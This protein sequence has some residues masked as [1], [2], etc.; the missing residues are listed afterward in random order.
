M[1]MNER[2]VN[3]KLG[4]KRNG[5][6]LTY[7]AVR[8]VTNDEEFREASFSSTE[9]AIM[10]MDYNKHRYSWVDNPEG[11]VDAIYYLWQSYE[12]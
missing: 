10:F 1:G 5:E 8:Y 7:I 6:T 3:L 4:D 2:Y 9:E 12:D 11:G